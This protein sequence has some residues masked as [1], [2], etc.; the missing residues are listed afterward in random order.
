M[1]G[2]G[3]LA[4]GAAVDDISGNATGIVGPEGALGLQYAIAPNIN[5]DVRYRVITYFLFGVPVS[6][7]VFRLAISSLR[8]STP[9]S[10]DQCSR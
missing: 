5:A 10:T 9:P 6:C 1:F 7:L 3:F 8:R 2:N 4:A